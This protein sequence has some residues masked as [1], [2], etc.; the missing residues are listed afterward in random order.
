M[1]ED[2]ADGSATSDTTPT[3]AG[4]TLPG[5]QVD[6]LVDGN[7]IGTTTANSVGDFSFT[8]AVPLNPGTHQASAKAR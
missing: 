8:P 2:P 1:L 7:P 6:I 4:T 5:A 3:F